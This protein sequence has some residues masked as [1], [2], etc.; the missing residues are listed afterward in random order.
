MRSSV[1]VIAGSEPF[2]I[3]GSTH[4]YRPVDLFAVGAVMA[5]RISV[6]FEVFVG[7]M[8]IDCAS[9]QRYTQRKSLPRWISVQ[10]VK[11]WRLLKQQLKGPKT[12]G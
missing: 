10:E 6:L 7:C 12:S 4:H 8:P 11:L 3:F 9:R 5:E 1:P 2:R